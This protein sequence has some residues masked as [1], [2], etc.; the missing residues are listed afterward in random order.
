MERTEGQRVR[1]LVGALLAVPAHVRRLDRDGVMPERAIESTHRAL[2]GVGTQD[3][4]DEPAAAGPLRT[5]LTSPA[6]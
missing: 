4:L 2:V 5:S 6:S 1:Q 3:L